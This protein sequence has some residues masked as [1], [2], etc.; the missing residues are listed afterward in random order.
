MSALRFG[1]F[2]GG[3]HRQE[4]LCYSRFVGFGLKFMGGSLTLG[5]MSTE[6]LEIAEKAKRLSHEEWEQLL[7][8]LEDIADDRTDIGSVLEI[9]GSSIKSLTIS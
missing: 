2:A 8:L 4:C 3:E 6:V 1:G 5:G 9:T 7:D